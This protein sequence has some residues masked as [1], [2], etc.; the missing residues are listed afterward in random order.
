MTNDRNQDFNIPPGFRQLE[1]FLEKFKRDYPHFDRNVFVMMPF[2]SPSADRIFEAVRREL[3]DHG[4]IALRADKI[5][6][7]VAVWWN[8]VTYMLGSSYGVVIFEAKDNVP[9]N[10]NVAAESGFMLAL[11]RPVLFLAEN[12][13]E[14]LPV[15]YAGLH[16]EWFET[17]PAEEIDVNVRSLVGDWIQNDLSYVNYGDK[18]LIVFVS[19]GGT[20]RCVMAKAILREMLDR[21]KLTGVAV[22][23]AAIADPHHATISPS[24]RKAIA[25]LGQD[26]WI[27]NHRPRKM[28]AYMQDRAD[29]IIGLSEF[30]LA[31]KP[32]TP[33]KYVMDQEIFGHSIANP[34][35]DTED[36]ESL[37]RYV[38][39]RDDLQRVISDNFDAILA[40]AGATPSF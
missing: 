9:F 11:D 20:C 12:K 37:K 19:L 26:R 29:L 36:D 27:E 31:R 1:P 24:A 30:P 17:S 22:E 2:S 35:P 15:D 14:K 18:K 38:D 3:E 6:Y 8:I 4:L 25:A 10:P 34:Y 21:H 40:R 16:F 7:S 5:K 28:S 13:L 33:Q 39:V 32:E 23:A